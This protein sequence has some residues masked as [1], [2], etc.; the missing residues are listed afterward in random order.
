MRSIALLT[1]AAVH[2]F[3]IGFVVVAAGRILF[4]LLTGRPVVL[5]SGINLTS[6]PLV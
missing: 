4:G 5:A 2:V 6:A 3:A 1:P